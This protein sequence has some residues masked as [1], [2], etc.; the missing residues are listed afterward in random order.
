MSRPHDY[1]PKAG[2]AFDAWQTN[3]IE[4]VDQFAK[5][6]GLT[7]DQVTELKQTGKTWEKRYAE[8]ETAR[9]AYR[10]AAAG[11]AAAKDAYVALIRKYAASIQ[12]NANATDAIRAAFGLTIRDTTPTAV[13]APSSAPVVSIDTSERLRHTLHSSDAAM[14]LRKA[15][16][17]GVIG[18]E[19]WPQV[20]EVATTSQIANRDITNTLDSFSFVKLATRTPAVVEFT[21]ADAGRTASYVLRWVNTRGDRGPLSAVAQATVGG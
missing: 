20:G 18:A 9:A 16:P 12:Q 21:G 15:K 19:I 11:K 17:A 10:E 8:L 4:A 6:L 3:F 5:V 2:G 13:E 7:D 1:I 14:P